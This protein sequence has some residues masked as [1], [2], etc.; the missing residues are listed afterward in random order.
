M[1]RKIEIILPEALADVPVHITRGTESVE[2][3]VNTLGPDA[4]ATK[5]EQGEGQKK[6]ALIW[7][8]E[9]Y[10]KVALDDIEWIEADG[11]Y[12]TFHLT[13]GRKLPVSHNL[14]VIRNRLPESD[15]IQIHRSHVINIKHMRTLMGNSVKV[16]IQ[17]LYISR[18]YRDAFFARF[19]FLGTK[20][21]HHQ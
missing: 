12:T 3:I 5:A 2:I 6:Y 11:S 8:K 7:C 21:I 10:C 9:D 19:V 15:F 20:S 14:A 18:K 13:D 1:T 17:K 16:G 4:C